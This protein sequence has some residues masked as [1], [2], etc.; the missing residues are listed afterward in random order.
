MIEIAAVLTNRQWMRAAKAWRCHLELPADKILASQLTAYIDGKM[1]IALEGPA[2]DKSIVDISPA[3]VVDVAAKG[4]KFFLIIETCWEKQ[5]CIGPYLTNLSGEKVTVRIAAEDQ[6]IVPPEEEAQAQ[7]VRGDISPEIVKG[8]HASWF[9]NEKFWSYLEG[10]IGM[11]CGKI[12][13]YGGEKFCKRVFKE[14]MEVK[15]C[16]EL[17]Q[18]AF[19]VMLTDFNHFVSQR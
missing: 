7:P 17:T 13:A 19:D 11:E 6:E 14:H 5:A 1:H 18:A 2:P 8:L 15:S 4:K 10:K 12:K 3:F 9:H 16:T